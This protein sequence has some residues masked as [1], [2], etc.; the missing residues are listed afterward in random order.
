MLNPACVG[1]NEICSK[2]SLD[3]LSPASELL[4]HPHFPFQEPSQ[5]PACSHYLLPPFLLQQKSSLLLHPSADSG[6]F[7]F[8]I[9]SHLN[10]MAIP[11]LSHWWCPAQ[12]SVTARPVPHAQASQLLLS[13]HLAQSGAWA[14]V[15]Y[16]EYIKD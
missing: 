5:S 15:P 2:H 10:L 11:C 6:A 7:Q 13:K 4:S 9:L 14:V 16:G 8:S 3:T 1:G 12:L